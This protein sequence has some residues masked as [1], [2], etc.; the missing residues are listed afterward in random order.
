MVHPANCRPVIDNL[1][2]APMPR[3]R[4][5]GAAALSLASLALPRRARAQTP[6]RVGLQAGHWRSIELPDELRSLRG[7]GGT[8]GG[9]VAEWELNLAVARRAAVRLEAAGVA[10]D[11]LPATIPPGYQA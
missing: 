3:R 10:V 6:W 1:L 5:L 11:V 4:L 8:A 2:S 7:N 9:G